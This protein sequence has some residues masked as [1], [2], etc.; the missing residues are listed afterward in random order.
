MKIIVVPLS[1]DISIVHPSRITRRSCIRRGVRG[2]SQ[3]GHAAPNLSL[4][5]AVKIFTAKRDIQ[6]LCV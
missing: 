4:K 3:C 2:R 6:A 1:L 5:T